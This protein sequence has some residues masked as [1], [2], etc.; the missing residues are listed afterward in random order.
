MRF[1]TLEDFDVVINREELYNTIDYPTSGSTAQ[2]AAL[3]KL[4]GA[5]NAAIAE[6]EGYLNNRYSSNLLFD[7]TGTSRN[8]LLVLKCTDMAV[9]HVLTLNNPEAMTDLR[10]E[11]YDNAIMVL[12]QINKLE[13]NLPNMPVP[14]DETK[15]VV[16]YG[17]NPR[18][19]NHF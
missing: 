3:A 8:S 13:L 1:L 17:S 10:K 6:M 4:N 15:E 12:N 18:R 5:V 9:Y 11:R 2:N 16:Y 7:A 19:S 14:A